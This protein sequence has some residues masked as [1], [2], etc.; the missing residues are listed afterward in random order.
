M[1]CDNQNWF[2]TIGAGFGEFTGADDFL[3]PQSP[4]NDDSLTETQY[5]GLNI[6]EANI[7]GFGYLWLHPNLDTATGG[8]FVCQGIKRSHLQAELFDMRAFSKQSDIITNDLHSFRLPN[9]YQVDV[10]EP[11]RSMRIRY[12][13]PA[14]ENF[15]D[16][17]ST[18]IMPV[19]MRGNNLHFEQAMRNQGELVL[20]GK[21]YTIDNTFNVRDRSWGQPRPEGHNPIP[22]MTWMTGTFDENFAFNFSAFDHPDLKPEWL[23][24]FDWPAENS[25]HDGWVYR[26]GELL[27]ATGGRKITRRDRHSGRP[28]THE[29]EL[30]DSR[31]RDY[32]IRGTTQAGLPWSGW[33]NCLVHLNLTRW[34]WDSR[35]GWGD[36]QECQW[37]DYIHQFTD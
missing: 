22:P 20:R 8:L 11:G 33:P 28:L 2:K 24:S 27:R 6:P 14:R 17:T 7:Y 5:F 12:Q 32:R 3:H 31:G 21:R 37:T 1:S 36:T 29:I 34:E 25:F 18:A 4:V 16:M 10:I 9:S 30:T 35:V 19:A 26:D 23:G 13:D 15:L